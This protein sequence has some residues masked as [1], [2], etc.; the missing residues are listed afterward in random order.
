M[1][2]KRESIYIKTQGADRSAIKRGLSWLI[3]TC[4]LNSQITEALLAVP[5]KKYLTDSGSIIPEAI[6]IKVASALAKGHKVKLPN[7]VAELSLLTEKQTIYE[8]NGP[9][10]AIYPTK[11]LLDKIDGLF[12]VTHVLVT[13]WIFDDIKQ[14]VETWSAHELGIEVPEPTKRAALNPVVVEALKSLTSGVNLST[15]IHHPSDKAAAIDL[16]QR[17]KTAGEDF[18]PIKV[19]MWLVSEGNWD[20]KLADDVMKVA[21]AVCEGRRVRGG[22]PSWAEDIIEQWRKKA[23]QDH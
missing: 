3:S 1:K 20:P 13:P 2:Q 17:L 15:G 19:R 22:K 6:D 18:D 11:E 12:G 8:C 14:W 16:F 21:Q 10:L 5:L 7:S 23:S 9:I 4:Y